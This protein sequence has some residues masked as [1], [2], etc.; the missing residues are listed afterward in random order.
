[1]Q[2]LVIVLVVLAGHAIVGPV[3]SADIVRLKNGNE[4]EGTVDSRTDR[5][6]VVTVAEMGQ[7]TFSADEVL[8][9]V[10]GG[11]ASDQAT[12]AQTPPALEEAT[13]EKF[14]VF[15]SQRRGVRI[16]YPRGW[17]LKE[18]PERT[19]YV[20]TIKPDPIIDPPAGI[21]PIVIELFK[22]Y[23]ASGMFG[24]ERVGTTEELVEWHAH[25]AV[26][27]GHRIVSQTPLQIQGGSARLDETEMT[28]SKTG[29]TY[30]MLV[31]AAAKGDVL[32]T[33]Y[34]QAS[35]AQFE[36]YRDMC[37][38]VMRRFQPFSAG[39]SDNTLLDRE[40]NRIESEGITAFREG[41]GKTF[42][43]RF[44][45]A[46]QRNPANASH[47]MNYGSLLMVVAQKAA[48]ADREAILQRS[49]REL[50]QAAVLLQV[51][52]KPRGDAPLMAQVLF[53]LGDIAA[54][55]RGDHALAKALY[56][57]SLTYYP[58][59]GAQEALKRYQDTPG[60]ASQPAN[61]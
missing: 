2:R 37:N 49:E 22:Y 25:T 19:P 59:E 21:A 29:A 13:D 8:E 20:V 4:I 41:D 27:I 33:L 32:S 52:E 10:P 56:Q 46:M 51:T 39:A 43:A 44:E 26:E 50:Q 1:M 57:K 47:H 31:M 28:D 54:Y 30:H 24:L 48:V 23:H 7:M 18:R 36:T 45:E 15:H 53:L 58:H 6:I 38:E 40:S 16:A 61:H 11:A 34:C 12:G 60:P 14:R 5:E 3:A 42:F 9:I 17:Y 55:G 35:T